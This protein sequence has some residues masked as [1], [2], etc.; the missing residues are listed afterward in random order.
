MTITNL[1]KHSIAALGLAT[2]LFGATMVEAGKT[3]G[4]RLRP[5]TGFHNRPAASSSGFAQ[6]RQQ[7][8]FA[9]PQVVRTAPIQRPAPATVVQPQRVAPAPT[10][11][12]APVQRQYVAPQRVYRTSWFG[13]F[14]GR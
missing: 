13:G 2:I 10:Q 7:P 1:K 11:H 5:G 3:G 14:F 9:A 6:S 8:V 4:D 12:V